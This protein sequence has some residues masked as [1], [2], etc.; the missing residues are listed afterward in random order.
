MLLVVFFAVRIR[1]A[2]L[3]LL[4]MLLQPVQYLWADACAQ[5]NYK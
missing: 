2:A 1:V 4:L 5:K 3:L